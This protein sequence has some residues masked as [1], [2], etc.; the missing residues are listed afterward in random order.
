MNASIERVFS[1][2]TIRGAGL[3]DL[4]AL[5]RLE[6]ICFGDDAWPMWDL[7]GVLVLPNLVRLKSVADGRM[8][9]FVGGDPHPAE[10]VGWI[11]TIGVL[12]EYRRRGMAVELLAACEELM[13]LPVVRL[14][15]R[16]SNEGALRLYRREGYRMVDSW[17]GYYHDGEDALVLEKNR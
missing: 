4:P 16:R 11:A 6:H 15:V 5:R 2:F 3:A 7:V 9:G 14:S 13:G 8:V 10:G 1:D 12:P 17:T